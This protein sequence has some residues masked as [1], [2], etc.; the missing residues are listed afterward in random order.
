MTTS[1]FELPI[2]IHFNNDKNNQFFKTDENLFQELELLKT[3]TNFI[4]L[5]N[6]S[7]LHR[8]LNYYTTDT[9]Y[10]KETQSLIKNFNQTNESITNKNNTNENNTNEN[11]RFVELFRNIN[12]KTVNKEFN[13]IEYEYFKHLNK[14]TLC[15]TLMTFQ[16]LF[17]P[18]INLLTPLLFLIL[19]FF[20]IK[21]QKIEMN[22]AEYKKVLYGYLKNH[23]LG[24]VI[25]HF[26]EIPNSQKLYTLIMLF[27]YFYNMYQN[28]IS[29]RKFFY[30][31]KHINYF[32]ENLT[33]FIEDVNEKIE[34]FK[35]IVHTHNLN[36][37]EEFISKTDTCMAS[38]NSISDEISKMYISQNSF[39]QFM[40]ISKKRKLFY[41]LMNE[42]DIIS[43]INYLIEFLD[44]YEIIQKIHNLQNMENKNVGC[45]A[46]EI[47]D[48]SSQNIKLKMEGFIHPYYIHRTS[49]LPT[50][51]LPT[52][53]TTDIS[54]NQKTNSIEINKN[55]ILTGPNASGKTT[56]LKAITCNLL[57]SQIFGFGSYTSCM[58]KPFHKFYSYLNIPDTL[59]RD[60][61]F[62]AEIRRCKNILDAIHDNPELNYFIIFDELFSGTNYLESLASCY[63]FLKDL[64]QKS[65]I[66]YILT[67]HILDLNK[68]LKN[69]NKF[70]CMA[71][72]KTET[73]ELIMKYELQNGISEILGGIQTLTRFEFPETI[74]SNTKK[75]MSSILRTNNK[76][77]AVVHNSK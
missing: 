57:F 7:L 19:P 76:K 44:Y 2:E 74:I 38:I 34:H 31:I 36:K 26:S 9:Q 18:L 12:H 29:T 68:Y 11:Q 69:E 16:Q 32:Y 59:E 15:L 62:E 54:N 33:T 10:L 21:I 37:Y 28:F 52:S 42:T 66:T 39:L 3:F 5:S 61:L 41:I 64:N 50:S 43:H 1:S 72:E 17:S 13:Y 70:S 60:S 67:T 35:Q 30:S 55:I 65:N 48:P 14:N 24:K 63:G 73:D 53:E 8:F 23:I 4:D 75:I 22:F 45:M 40:D 6:N 27:F 51:E 56:L 58:A 77:E 47:Q 20:I 71:V 25:F 49:E 46:F